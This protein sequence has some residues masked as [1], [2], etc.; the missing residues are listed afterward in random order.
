MKLV[1]LLLILFRVSDTANVSEDELELERQVRITNKPP[2]KTFVVEPNLH[3]DKFEGFSPDEKSVKFG[4]REPCPVG[5]V[6]I[7]RVTKE[8]LRRARSVPKMPSIV[9]VE[10]YALPSN[11]HVVSLR[12]NLVENVKYGCHGATTVYNLTVAQD[13][14][15]SHNMW[16]ETGPPDHISMIAAGWQVTPGLYGDNVPGFFTYWMRLYPDRQGIKPR[17]AYCALLLLMEGDLYAFAIRIDQDR[18]TG[19]WWLHCDGPSTKVG[20]WPKELFLYLRNGSLHTAWGGV[21]LAGS[22]GDCP[23]MA[24][25]HKPD[26]NFGHATYF[27]SLAWV[28]TNGDIVLPTQKISKWVDKSNVYGFKNHHFTIRGMKGYTISFGGPGVYCGG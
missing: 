8:K 20:Y 28:D 12:E 13:Q 15:S 3:F 10:S 16:I 21:G 26:D 24:S 22:N 11:Q 23:P 5:T 17:N 18:Q 14:F 19:N 1:L 25:G 2:V 4:P 27:R 6:P 7:P 9:A